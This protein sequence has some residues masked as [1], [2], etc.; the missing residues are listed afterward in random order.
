MSPRNR[1]IC[2][3]AALCLLLPPA[4]PAAAQD[5]AADPLD[6]SLSMGMLPPGGDEEDTVK[7]LTGI[8]TYE[9]EGA[10][11]YLA[12]V[13]DALD[14]LDLPE[15]IDCLVE[16]QAEWRSYYCPV[17][18][19]FEKV[20]NTAPGRVSIP[21]QL[22]P[23]EDYALHEDFSALVSYHAVILCE[24]GMA[25]ETLAKVEF[26]LTK[27]GVLVARGEDPA[28]AAISS[29]AFCYTPQGE[30]YRADVIWDYSAV[31]RHTTGAY[32][33]SGSLLLPACF[34]APD[35][36]Q[37]EY[38]SQVFVVDPDRIDLTGVL[39]DDDQELYCEWLFRVPQPENMVIEYAVGAVE[40]GWTASRD[41][42]YYYGGDFLYGG[43][44]ATSLTVEKD[45][46]LPDTD[47]YF[48]VL[49]G[50][51]VSGILHVN[52]GEGAEEPEAILLEG[53][54]PTS[55]RLI[56]RPV[57]DDL[58]DLELPGTVLCTH[59]RWLSVACAVAWDTTSISTEEPGWIQIKGDITPPAGY[60]AEE[61][62][63]ACHPV[64]LVEEGMEKEPLASVVG[65]DRFFLVGRGAEHIDWLALEDV[66]ERG[67]P[68][69]L[70]YE[71]GNLLWGEAPVT[72]D[73]S[74]VDSSK[75]GV[76]RATG[77][78][79]LPACF[80][81]PEGEQPLD[82]R[83]AVVEPDR[84]DLSAFRPANS[85]NRVG[86][87]RWLYTVADCENI[88]LDYALGDGDWQRATA[89]PGG[90][91]MMYA[92]EVPCQ[93]SGN[94]L[95][96]QLAQ[97]DQGEHWFRLLYGGEYS[98]VLHISV[99][100]NLVVDWDIGG[101]RG[102][103]DQEPQ[104]PPEVEQ[105]APRPGTDRDSRGEA[106]GG[107]SAA[108]STQPSA[109]VGETVDAAAQSPDDLDARQ[110]P[111]PEADGGE[112]DAAGEPVA[113]RDPAEVG[114]DKTPS[115]TAFAD[116]PRQ[117]QPDPNANSSNAPD[118][119]MGEPMME[120]ATES[121]LSISGLRLREMLAVAGD[122]VLL[123]KQGVS[124]ELPA[125]FLAGLE[126][127]DTS[128]L[129]VHIEKREHAF[130][131]ELALDDVPLSALPLTAVYLPFTLAEGVNADDLA[132]FDGQGREVSAAVYNA[133]LQLVQVEIE[134][135]GTYTVAPR[136]TAVLP[137][138]AAEPG[139][140]TGATGSSGGRPVLPIAGAVAATL[141]AGFVL[142]RRRRGI[143]AGGNG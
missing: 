106:K 83:V 73:F 92:E 89:A 91:G 140:S 133:A 23:E 116:P 118:K 57:G 30:Y 71:T 108:Q 74:A 137:V 111:A 63:A 115:P 5:G 47:Y 119:S 103:A 76:Y 27:N 44:N 46:L 65:A 132:C 22:Q 142:L 4:L 69:S 16:G 80:S 41:E 7:I 121:T 102:G 6:P 52:T 20:D 51:T 48:R 3:G 135:T 28:D 114:G 136:G 134:A 40:S 109:P 110:P 66:L 31:D 1:L 84:I 43:Y 100:E 15:G 104:E 101:D 90:A 8:R 32:P 19:D 14:S 58:S 87:S 55:Y 85:M 141:C 56:L 62:F 34:A 138:S 131:L 54:D 96:V 112:A 93:Y 72:W 59:S 35:D 49:Y 94:V 77:S 98:N 64:M 79:E 12:N 95:T 99:D 29:S 82:V 42:A 68:S 122:T 25:R 105:P 38:T 37:T 10:M 2:I 143:G 123:E 33:V 78:I 18:W 45:K 39:R 107:S 126:L 130:V 86:S 13:G 21:G 70:S 97:L 36:A 88:A 139:G 128:R 75:A 50:D 11:I 129:A 120:Y 81:L 9:G 127:E 53:V 61:G 24:E 17:V 117:T 124:V 26:S 67:L 125:E 113:E 60:R